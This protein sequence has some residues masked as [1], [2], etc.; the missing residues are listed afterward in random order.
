MIDFKSTIV[1]ILLITGLTVKGQH[2]NTVGLN[3]FQLKK[4]LNGALRANDYYSQIDFLEALCERKPNKLKYKYQLAVAYQHSRNYQRALEEFSKAYYGDQEK[5]SMALFHMGQIMKTSQQYE[6]ALL[7][8]NRFEK[9]HNHSKEAKLDK[10]LLKAEKEGCKIAMQ[11]IETDTKADIAPIAGN[12]N[13]ANIEFSPQLINPTTLW[14]VSLPSNNI[15]FFNTDSMPY[16]RIYEA[17]LE[18][19]KWIRKNEV[20]FPHQANKEHIGSF[21]LSEDQE[22]MYFTKCKPNWQNRMVCN[23]YFTKKENGSWSDPI[24]LPEEVHASKHTYTQPCVGTSSKKGREIIYFVSDKKGGKGGYD[25]WYTRYRI[26]KNKFEKARNAGKK[27]NSKADELAPTFDFESHRLYYASNGKPSIGGFDIQESIG[28]RSKWM[29]P[30]KNAGTEIN[31]SYDDLYYLPFKGNKSKALLISNR[32]GSIDLKHPHCCDDIFEVN[33]KNI[34]QVKLNLKTINEENNK[35]IEGME[36]MLAVKDSPEGEILILQR[37]KTD[38]MGMAKLFLEPELEYQIITES[39]THFNKSIEI[40]APKTDKSIELKRELKLK[41]IPSGE[42]VIPNI[43]YPFDKAYLTD[44]AQLAIDTSIYELLVENPTLIVEIGSH[45]DS[46]GTEKYNE[47]LSHRRAQSVVNYLQKKGIDKKRLKAKGYG[48]S[49]PVAP[50]ANPDGT[51][52]PEGR[53]KNRRTSFKVIG[54]LDLDIYYE[55]P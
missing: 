9:H 14:Y 17:K 36:I 4:Q 11:E 24:I 42:I 44:N 33:W 5:Y 8:F 39:E 47:H 38:S 21:A 16:R 26:S 34:V 32:E 7:Y 30:A 23:I 50:N 52:N 29:Y 35:L 18:N 40:K 10:K 19:G 31:S 28:E 20:D 13:M 15:V 51:D 22:R 37:I 41:E 45:T 43:Y 2:Q 12:L 54:H 3:N 6:M 49:T 25:I 55:E 1:F 27:I 48:E 53:A 46:K